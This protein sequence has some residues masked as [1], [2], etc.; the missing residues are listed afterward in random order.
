MRSVS[1]RPGI[2][3]TIRAPCGPS[4][5]ASCLT[6]IARPGRS[7]SRSASPGMGVFT[8]VDSTQAMQRSGCGAV[9]HHRAADP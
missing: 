8:D 6:S 4:S 7:R 3:P 2:R 9:P 1:I 5:S